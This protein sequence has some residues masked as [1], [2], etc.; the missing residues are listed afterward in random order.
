MEVNF[1]SSNDG[2]PYFKNNV[3]SGLYQS[4]HALPRPKTQIFSPAMVAVGGLNGHARNGRYVNRKRGRPR[5]YRSHYEDDDVDGT[6]ESRNRPLMNGII[7]SRNHSLMNGMPFVTY[8]Q[9]RN[10]GVA[11]RKEMKQAQ[12]CTIPSRL[13]DE[14]KFSYSEIRNQSSLKR[15]HVITCGGVSGCLECY[16][17]N[18]AFC[19][20]SSCF[21]ESVPGSYHRDML[22]ANQ[23]GLT[24]APYYPMKIPWQ[25]LNNVII[26]R[27]TNVRHSES[28][29]RC[30]VKPIDPGPVII[31][32]FSLCKDNLKETSKVED[33]HFQPANDDDHR[34]TSKEL[35]V[36]NDENKHSND[37][38]IIFLEKENAFCT[39][40]STTA[41]GRTQSV[42]NCRRQSFGESSVLPVSKKRSRSSKEDDIDDLTETLN[43][44]HEDQDEQYLSPTRA[45]ED[46]IKQQNIDLYEIYHSKFYKNTKQLIDGEYQKTNTSPT[47]EQMVELRNSREK[48]NN[49]DDDSGDKT[50]RENVAKSNAITSNQQGSPAILNDGIPSIRENVTPKPQEK[51]TD[52]LEEHRKLPSIGR[53][54]S[55]DENG[56]NTSQNEDPPSP[57][58]KDEQDSP[59]TENHYL[60][61]YRVDP[62][63][64]RNAV[65]CNLPSGGHDNRSPKKTAIDLD[66][67]HYHQ[68]NS[69]NQC[70]PECL[71]NAS[72]KNSTEE[73]WEHFN[74]P[75][76]RSIHSLHG[77]EIQVS[78]TIIPSRFDSTILVERNPVDPGSPES[79]ASGNWERMNHDIFQESAVQNNSDTKSHVC[80]HCG[81]EFTHVSSL[82][83]HVRTHTG[84]KP[85]KCS[86]CGKHFA[87]SG[88][89]TA[90]LRTHTGDRPFEC[91][92][93][94]K[95]FAQT[96]TLAN[97]I[98][99][100]TGQKPFTCSYCKRKFAQS[101]TRNKHE[102][103]H[104]KEKPYICKFCGRSFAQSATL[105]RH[106]RTHMRENGFLCAYCGKEFPYLHALDKHLDSHNR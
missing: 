14:R 84:Q 57:N 101:S 40:P 66:E 59:S 9:Q 35:P 29:T 54:S 45:Y 28:G 72:D 89:L 2:K 63:L 19:S 61:G 97:H 71:V 85:F 49:R 106:M 73:S 78:Q 82:N 104:T 95:R 105:T 31:E 26:D 39:S 3:P 38:S 60:N 81:R 11:S 25:Q 56:T 100:H 43:R 50:Q 44:N 15:D 74:Q 24:H 12:C 94:K 7:E 22:S 21:S 4:V 37:E 80:D 99:T 103:S 92:I 10:A 88:V 16:Y 93:C 13:I 33:D 76:N 6:I 75:Q 41:A 27:N 65:I 83:N 52:S 32:C 98:R 96:T 86:F 79:L 36:T 47:R 34:T 70:S 67:A 53:A 46:K 77:H 64:N 69:V 68:R 1:I 90:H 42:I 18:T 17:G 55:V 20:Y 87:Q 102:L 62:F 30:K 5:K 51:C 8:M 91:I 23:N 58:E 48:H